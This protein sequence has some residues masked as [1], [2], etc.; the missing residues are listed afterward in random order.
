[1]RGKRGRGGMRSRGSEEHTSELQ[2]QPNLVCRLL[3]EKK[4][5][6]DDDVALP[7][8]GGRLIAHRAAPR[9]LHRD[10]QRGAAG[11]LASQRVTLSNRPP[12]RARAGDPT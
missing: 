8:R 2:S 5:Y 10:E 9:I 1:M 12:V 11:P 3:L 4:I 7:H 6:A